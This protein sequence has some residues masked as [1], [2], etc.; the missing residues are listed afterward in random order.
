MIPWRGD[1]SHYHLISKAVEVG[2][3]EEQW[4][5]SQEAQI[6]IFALSTV[7]SVKSLGFSLPCDMLL[8]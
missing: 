2:R 8:S 1:I 7:I 3:K 5:G 6:R 4:T